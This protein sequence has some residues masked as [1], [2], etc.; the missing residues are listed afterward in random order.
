MGAYMHIQWRAK[1]MHG[2]QKYRLSKLENSY[3]GS[4]AFNSLETF[5]LNIKDSIVYV[6][7]VLNYSDDAVLLHCVDASHMPWECPPQK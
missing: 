7:E 3:H 6:C 4:G 5:M 2:R 1:R